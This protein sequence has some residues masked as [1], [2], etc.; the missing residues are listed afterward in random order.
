MALTNNSPNTILLDVSSNSVLMEG[1][2]TTGQSIYPGDL[3]QFRMTTGTIE[4]YHNASLQIAPLL[5]AVENTAEGLGV[6]DIYA[7]LTKIFYVHMR[8]GDLFW[9][10]VSAAAV[11]AGEAMGGETT[12]GNF[13]PTTGY[14]AATTQGTYDEA[15]VFAAEADALTTGG[16]LVKLVA[17]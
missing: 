5:I 14:I 16:R 15:L 8:P 12:T 17:K 10:R 4:R 3:V 9:G 11:E 7:Q 13:I 1:T 6:D 2:V